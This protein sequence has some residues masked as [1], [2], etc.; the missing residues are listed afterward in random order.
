MTYRSPILLAKVVTAAFAPFVVGCLYRLWLCREGIGYADAAGAGAPAADETLRAF[1]ARW[2]DVESAIRMLT[3]LGAVVFCVWMYRIARNL[4][5]FDVPGDMPGMF[6]VAFFIPFLNLWRPYEYVK[7]A[8]IGSDPEA[9]TAEERAGGRSPGFLLAW[10]VS[11]QVSNLVALLSGMSV[12]GARSPAGFGDAMALL[13]GAT[14]ILLV[15]LALMLRVVWGLSR[16]QELRAQSGLPHAV[17]A[18]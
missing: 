6:V 11:W 8:W 5:S 1:D 13:G 9:R 15:S 10:W 18:R 17:V 7:E 3:V 12:A 2:A 4:R 16:R 14:A